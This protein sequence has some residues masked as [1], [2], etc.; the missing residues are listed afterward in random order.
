MLNI[1]LVCSCC[2]QIKAQHHRS[3]EEQNIRGVEV[4]QSAD[5]FVTAA[6]GAH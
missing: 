2:I 5:S 1:T 4:F 3:V 6:G